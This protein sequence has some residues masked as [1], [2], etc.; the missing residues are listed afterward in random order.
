MVGLLFVD[1]AH[2]VQNLTG[3]II[4]KQCEYHPFIPIRSVY[5]LPTM[6]LFCFKLDFLFVIN[7]AFR[8][9]HE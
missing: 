7:A 5:N 3:G 1:M 8:K 9:Q 6:R 2:T 4:S